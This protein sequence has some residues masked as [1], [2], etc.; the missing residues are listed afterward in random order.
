[1]NSTNDHGIAFGDF[2]I[3]NEEENGLRVE[4]SSQQDP[5]KGLISDLFRALHAENVHLEAS[6]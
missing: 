4:E 1:M 5:M 2:Q 3:V 6:S